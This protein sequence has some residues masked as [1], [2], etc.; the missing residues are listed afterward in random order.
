MNRKKE[1]QEELEQI[2]PTLAKLQPQQEGD[3]P[4]LYFEGLADKIIDK[5]AVEQSDSVPLL[6]RIWTWLVQPQV[7]L[8]LCS[9]MLVAS[10]FLVSNNTS[11]YPA[12]VVADLQPSEI[13]TYIT[14]NIED[15][16][17][18]T[19]LAMQIEGALFDDFLMEDLN[20]NEFDQLL[21]D[22]LEDI[23]ENLLEDFL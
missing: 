8:A 21:E 1:I 14:Q 7:G 9:L 20:D 11:S 15:F 6:S 10:I 3:V 19:F 12:E 16:D 23:D 2:A 5:A 17:E 18:D 22:V 4:Y 13:N